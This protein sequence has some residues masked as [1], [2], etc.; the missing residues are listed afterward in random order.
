MSD[1]REDITELVRTL[2]LPLVDDPDAVE[3]ISSETEDG[4]LLVEVRVA[5]SDAGKVIGRQGRVIKAIRTLS[6]AAGS[7]N[8]VSVEVELYED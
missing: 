7:R 6:R 8:G 2:V 1:T 4:S 3:L 5:D